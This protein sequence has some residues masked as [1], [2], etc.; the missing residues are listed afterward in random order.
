MVGW[1]GVQNSDL[2][3]SLDRA[4]PLQKVKFETCHM[5]AA[6]G[7]TIHAAGAKRVGRDFVTGSAIPS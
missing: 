6:V 1:I 2:E 3:G 4:W 7:I 5:P